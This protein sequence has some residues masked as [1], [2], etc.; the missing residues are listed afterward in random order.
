MNA[1]AKPGFPIPSVQATWNGISSG[2]WTPASAT[3]T[4]STE[5]V[6]VRQAKLEPLRSHPQAEERRDV[7]C[8]TVT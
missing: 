2:G 6:L 5:L 3:R 1:S 4:S 8:R 7:Y